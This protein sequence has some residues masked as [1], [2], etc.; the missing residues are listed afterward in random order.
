MHIGT[1]H[2]VLFVKIRLVDDMDDC[3]PG[4]LLGSCY[5]K[6]SEVHHVIVD[7]L[8]FPSQD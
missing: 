2:P 3:H 5:F 6:F 8:V 7:H 1:I 4:L